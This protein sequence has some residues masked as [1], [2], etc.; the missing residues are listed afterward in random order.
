M[1]PGTAPAWAPDRLRLNQALVLALPAAA[2]LLGVLVLAVGAPAG[3]GHRHAPGSDGL[4]NAGAGMALAMM[5]PLS[6]PLLRGVGEASLWWLVP[7]TLTAAL[8]GYLGVWVVAGIGLHAPMH[9]LLHD[10]WLSPGAAM[11]VPALILSSLCAARLWRRS[12]WRVVASCGVSRPV[13]RGRALTDAGIWG[14]D[15]AGRCVR[16][17]ALPMLLGALGHGWLTLLLLTVLLTA[18]RLLA[19]PPRVAL[20][21]GYLVLG[22]LVGLGWTL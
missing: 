3:N 2:C 17:C 7:R 14:A 11:V 4:V 13:R 19:S 9:L 22:I 15:H 20:T 6:L 21:V 18:E 16:V 12:H 8:A 1:H 10:G 5:A